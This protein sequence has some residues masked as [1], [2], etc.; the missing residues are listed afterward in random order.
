[1][2]EILPYLFQ[3]NA[4]VL[5]FYLLYRL[6]FRSLTFYTTNRYILL[7]GLLFSLL[8]PFLDLPQLFEQS[9]AISEGNSFAMQGWPAATLSRQSLQPDYWLWIQLLFWGVSALLLLRLLLR[10]YSL[11]RLH[12]NTTPAYYQHY[13]FRK[14]SLPVNPFS[15]WRT[16]YLNPDCHQ[17]E[18]LGAILQHE[19]VHIDE[20]HTLDVLVA[21]VL[22]LF[23]WFN[24]AM[25]LTKRAIGENLEFI[26]D[27]RLLQGGMESKAYQYCLLKISRLSQASSLATNFN[28]STIKTRISM[29]NKRKSA[30]LH[31]LK[32]A[33]ILPLA[34]GLLYACNVED[35]PAEDLLP[36]EPGTAEQ[37]LSAETTYYLD[38]EESSQAEVNQ[39]KPEEIAMVDVYKGEQAINSYGK[40]EVVVITTKA[41]SERQDSK[42]PSTESDNSKTDVKI[43]S[44]QGASSSEANPMAEA[45]T[46]T[47]PKKC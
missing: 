34:T 22:L 15:F 32:Y 7:L 9:L 24:P 47:R 28:F 33:L 6:V 8:Y 18:E 39:L 30:S 21:E 12:A 3:V 2:P 17:A 41:N 1:M 20:L 16:M 19:K 11:Y 36:R 4:A 44:S 23:C 14:V 40:K 29:M 45:L 42:A 37:T 25:W 27:Q 31:M 35:E 13:R 10:L 26:T 5:A 38:G 43:N 46:L